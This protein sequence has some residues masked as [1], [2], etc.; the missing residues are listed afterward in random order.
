MSKKRIVFFVVLA[1]I[2]VGSCYYSYNYFFKKD[3]NISSGVKQEDIFSP[4]YTGSLTSGINVMGETNLL[5]EQKL[6]FNVNGTIKN[7]LVKEGDKVK[8]GDILA[9]LE[10]N[11]IENEL[12]EAQIKYDDAKIAL[13][14]KFLSMSKED[15]LKEEIALKSQLRKIEDSKYNLDKL[16]YDNDKKLNDLISNLEKEK[17]NLEKLKKESQ[18]SKTNLSKD[19]QDKKDDLDYKKKTLDDKKWSLE[20]S[21]LDEKTS[22]DKSLRDFD[23]L[24]KDMYD[25]IDSDLESF[26]QN[27]KSLNEI[28]YIDREETSSNNSNYIYFSAKNINYRNLVENYYFQVKGGSKTLQEKLKKIDKNKITFDELKTLLSQEKEISNSLYDLGLNLAKGANESIETQDFDKGV[29]SSLLSMGNSFRSTGDSQKKQI[30]GDIDKLKTQDSKKDLEEKSRI[31][32]ENL[33]KELKDLD[34]SIIDFEKEFNDLNL[35]FPEKL[36]D[37]EENIKDKEEA[38]KTLNKDLEDLKYQ[39][40]KSLEDAK[41][42]LENEKVDYSINSKNFLKKYSDI[43]S[44]DEIKVLQNAL[45]QAQIGIDQVKEKLKNYT[46]VAPFDGN[47]ATNTLKVGDKLSTDSTDDKSIYLINPKLIE[48]KMKLDQIDI[49]K[50]KKGVEG[51][52]S[53]DSQPGK[54]FT[55]TIDQ[56]DTKPIDENGAKKYVVKMVIDIGDLNIFS[57]MSANVEIVFEKID[58]AVLVPTMAIEQDPSTGENYVTVKQ[59]GKKIKK[60]V[61]TGIARDGVTQIISG[62]NVGDEVLEINFDANNFKQEDFNGGMG[63][64]IMY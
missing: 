34:K 41:I 49:V 53:F 20:K 25:K 38:I 57:G 21:I 27:L 43:K 52:V 56:I 7:V 61:Q 18:V 3:K 62:I 13:D 37:L 33:N 6:K 8:T 14:K 28:L 1:I 63:G 64:G 4:A 11:L 32:V 45:D 60:V 12:K 51:Q 36:K 55:G 39:N 31:K 17:F 10:T 47:I 26:L 35:L 22:L 9:S 54:V 42:A 15:K 44:S 19:L 23:S 48:I 46:L 5:S 58:D 16:K 40:N 59:N 50:I 24:S 29:I 30:D 2:L